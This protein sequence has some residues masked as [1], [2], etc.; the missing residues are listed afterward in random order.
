MGRI[1]EDSLESFNIIDSGWRKDLPSVNEESD[2]MSEE[3][4]ERF[5]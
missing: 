2:H 3:R 4:H 5:L 1:R